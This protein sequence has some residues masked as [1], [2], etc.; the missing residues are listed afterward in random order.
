MLLLQVRGVLHKRSQ[1]KHELAAADDRPV[2]E[3]PART[4]VHTGVILEQHGFM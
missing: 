4:L 3:R 2:P 1:H